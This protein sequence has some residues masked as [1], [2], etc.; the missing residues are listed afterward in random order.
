MSVLQPTLQND[1]DSYD[2]YAD[3]DDSY[4]SYDD[5]QDSSVDDDE[6]DEIIVISGSKTPKAADRGDKGKVG[7][8]TNNPFTGTKST[9]EKNSA[10]GKTTAEKRAEQNKRWAEDRARRGLPPIREPDEPRKYDQRLDCIS[11]YTDWKLVA[12]H[13]MP[14]CHALGF[15]A[16][17]RCGYVGPSRRQYTICLPYLL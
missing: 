16:Y 4:D 3:D 12:G 9:E 15:H 17:P 6:N 14:R 10:K 7:P 13:Q 2:S 8:K 11:M 5:S 1:D